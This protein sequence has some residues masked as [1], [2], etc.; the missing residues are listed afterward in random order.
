MK[1][2][3]IKF[4]NSAKGFGFIVPDEGGPDVFVHHSGLV[5]DVREGDNVQYS[6]EEGKKGINAV[7]VSRIS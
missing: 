2:G 1:K 7:N 4:Y 5:D 3:K 6:T